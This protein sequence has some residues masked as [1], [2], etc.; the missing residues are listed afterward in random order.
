MPHFKFLP[1]FV[2]RLVGLCFYLAAVAAW[3]QPQDS[4]LGGGLGLQLGGGHDKLGEGDLAVTVSAG[5]TTP[6]ANGSAQIF[7]EA[8]IPPATHI[9]SITQP[10]GAT[11]RAKI[12]LADSADVASLGDFRAVQAPKVGYQNDIWPGIPLESHSGKVK[13]VAAIQFKPG[14]RAETVALKG[15]LMCQQCNDGEGT[16]DARDHSFTAALCRDV[17][18]VTIP[19]NTPKP[20][21]PQSA[22]PT[23]P[24]SNPAPP[25]PKTSAA[26]VTVQPAGPPVAPHNEAR[27]GAL[28]W[29]HFTS[30]QALRELVGGLNLEQLKANVHEADSDLSFGRAI[31]FGFLGGLVLN[32]MPCVLPVIGLK[33]LSFVQQSGHHRMKAFTLNVWYSAG[34]MAVF[35]LLATLAVSPQKLGWGQLFGETWFTI[36]LAAVV[37]VMA[38]SF[39]GLWEVPLPTFLGGGKA[40]ELARK[41]GAV[42][43]FFKGAMTTLLATPCSAPYLAPALVWATAQPPLLTYAVFVSIGLGMASP[44]LVVGAFPEL[45]RFVPKPGPWMETFK[46][47]MGFVLIGTVVYLLTVIEPHNVVPTVGLLFGLWFGCWMIGRMD[48][49]ADAGAKLRTMSLAAAACCAVWIVMF[50]GLSSQ[51]VGKYAFPGLSSIMQERMAVD[52]HEGDDF[53]PMAGPKNVLVDFT[54]DWCVNCKINERVL[55]T[56]A[57]VN[58][59]QR[60]G[61][62]LLKADWTRR[63]KSV[64]VTRMLDVLGG[65]QIPV[66][67]VFSAKDPNHPTVFRGSY[68]EQDIVEALAKAGPSPASG[69]ASR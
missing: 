61:V 24:N 28:T 66:I 54:A 23:N 40:G 39:M 43:A 53:P 52:E 2:C 60:Q 67:A 30:V 63:E 6:D 14:V 58:E 35:M 16:C 45:L 29:R 17:H 62:V 4:L 19:D 8:V 18:P 65:R 20:A 13:W 55:R 69:L 31:F 38:L 56:D 44:Y 46:Q 9:Y 10:P 33:I 37:F 26:A 59:I 49:L 47:F 21:I 36:S 50:P 25:A 34:L 5:F 15:T 42:G 27:G 68:T 48:P 51:A 1:G 32:I 11:L 22:P 64:E 57:V 41:E 7:V 3:G 12:T